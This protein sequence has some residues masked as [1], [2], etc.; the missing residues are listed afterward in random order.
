MTSPTF[1]V[2][3]P[4]YN[5]A[6]T[7]AETIATVQ[8]QAFSDFEIIAIDDG[9]TDDS[10]TILLDIAA[11]DVRI[12]VV[13]VP[14]NGVSAARNLGAELANGAMLAF[15]DADDLWL[16]EK[17]RCHWDAHQ[18]DPDLAVSFA[19]I[20]FFW[21]EKRAHRVTYSTVPVGPLDAASLLAENAACTTSNIV[22]R[23]DVFA[24]TTR[25]R[26]DLCFAE[27]QEWLISAARAGHKIKGLDKYL[28]DYRMSED[29]LSAN[30]EAMF[31]GWRMVQNLH[32]DL[33][34][35][36][37][38]S[39]AEALYCR[40][41]ARRALRT[42]AAVSEVRR[43]A[44]RGLSTNRTAFLADRFRGFGTLI[45]AIICGVLPGKARRRLFA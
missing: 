31:A 44:W 16:P 14:N 32:S 36:S 42:G 35:P 13:S 25:F 22:V 6:A 45:G 34:H 40:Y 3:I 4:V 7:I 15:L 17:L 26:P 8:A 30:L 20:R 9:S 19:K 33:R 11:N 24:A 37:Q 39:A 12:R 29:G 41:L 2:I 43:F 28:V 10:L 23:R 27:D 21:A 5:A 38:K 18:A 1:S